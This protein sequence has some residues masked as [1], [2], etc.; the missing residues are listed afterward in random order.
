M[1]LF[2]RSHRQLLKKGPRLIQM[3]TSAQFS[4][5]LKIGLSSP[6]L[7]AIPQN[8]SPLPLTPLLKRDT[9]LRILTSIISTPLRKELLIESKHLEAEVTKSSN[10]GEDTM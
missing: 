8:L 7:Q 9:I 6:L 4:P 3:S 2:N 10:A 5:G 1:I